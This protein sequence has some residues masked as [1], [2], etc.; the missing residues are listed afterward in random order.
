MA[1]TKVLLAKNQK[2]TFDGATL[3]GVR[4]VDVDIDERTV[5]ITPWNSEFASTLPVVA[6]ATLR[7]LIYWPEDW[8]KVKAK[9]MVWPVQPVMVGV[10]NAY[11][12]K[13]LPVSVKVTQP[14]QGVV[15]WDCTFRA[16]SYAT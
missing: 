7:L 11:T 3:E 1:T 15:A 12:I 8:E 16:Y 10:T 5:D 13:C 9:F 4:E 14:I 6:D 2:V